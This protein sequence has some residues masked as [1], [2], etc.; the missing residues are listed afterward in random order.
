MCMRFW[1]RFLT[2]N[3]FSSRSS[4]DGAISLSISLCLFIQGAW[5]PAND[6]VLAQR[7]M[8]KP[9][10]VDRRKEYMDAVR[11]LNQRFTV[12]VKTQVSD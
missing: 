2:Y 4:A 8:V 7:K 10:M 11:S 3:V 12:F 9:K 1:A 5:R 6:S